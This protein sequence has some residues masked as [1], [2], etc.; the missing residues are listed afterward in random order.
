MMSCS[1]ALTAVNHS[2]VNLFWFTNFIWAIIDSL[3]TL[4]WPFNPY[5]R[6]YSIGYG[7]QM[8]FYVYWH[9][10][11]FRLMKM[12]PWSR[13]HNLAKIERSLTILCLFHLLHT[14]HVF[15]LVDFIAVVDDK[16]VK[17]PV[18][19]SNQTSKSKQA[20]NGFSPSSNKG[21]LFNTCCHLWVSESLLLFRGFSIKCHVWCYYNWFSM[22]WFL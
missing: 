14:F 22:F 21:S 17:E 6:Y 19:F 5:A 2:Q 10:F 3:H 18:K 9:I 16:F 4:S 1:S 7:G 20:F 8:V 12:S 11:A 13:K 15:W